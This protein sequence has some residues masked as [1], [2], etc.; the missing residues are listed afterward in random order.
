MRYWKANRDN[1]AALTDPA[2][3]AE[4]FD[5]GRIMA[6]EQFDRSL[7]HTSA[8]VVVEVLFAHPKPGG[9]WFFA[10]YHRGDSRTEIGEV[11]RPLRPISIDNEVTNELSTVEQIEARIQVSPLFR[12]LRSVASKDDLM[13]GPLTKAYNK[14][15]VTNAGI[16]EGFPLDGFSITH[17]ELPD[18]AFIMQSTDGR[19][20]P[21]TES[22]A[23]NVA[24]GAPS[25]GEVPGRLAEAS[26]PTR[27]E[28][29]KDE[30]FRAKPDDVLINI[31]ALGAMS[32]LV[33][34]S[35]EEESALDRVTDLAEEALAALNDGQRPLAYAFVD[36]A[37]GLLSRLPNE[38]RPR[39][40]AT[41]ALVAGLSEILRNTSLYFVTGESLMEGDK[42]I[43]FVVDDGKLVPGHV[44][45]M[46]ETP[47]KPDEE[48]PEIVFDVV[49]R[50]Q[51]LKRFGTDISRE[52]PGDDYFE[53]RQR[54]SRFAQILA[55][56]KGRGVEL[57]DKMTMSDIKN[58]MIAQNFPNGA[59]VVYGGSPVFVLDNGTEPDSP[60]PAAA[61]LYYG[62][63]DEIGIV[64]HDRM[65]RSP[66]E[67]AAQ[68]IE[69]DLAEGREKLRRV[70]ASIGDMSDENNRER[71]AGAI[72]GLM[73]KELGGP[74]KPA[75]GQTAALGAAAPAT[76]FLGD[77]EREQ[78]LD[79]AQPGTVVQT[80][81]GPWLIIDNGQIEAGAFLVYE[82]TG[83]RLVTR[84]ERSNF[85]TAGVIGSLPV[86]PALVA[87]AQAIQARIR[88]ILAEPGKTLSHDVDELSWEGLMGAGSKG[89]ELPGA[90]I[91][92]LQG[93]FA[94]GAAVLI[95][96]IGL[97]FGAAASRAAF[98]RRVAAA[99]ALY[100]TS[101]AWAAEAPLSP[102]LGGYFPALALT[103][104]FG[105]GPAWVIAQ[106]LA[107]VV[108]IALHYAGRS[109][110]GWQPW[111]VGGLGAVI[112]SP[113]GLW[114]GPVYGMIAASAIIAVLHLAVSNVERILPPSWTRLYFA[115]VL[116]GDGPPSALS[117]Q[118][119][120]DYVDELKDALSDSVDAAGAARAR[121][122]LAL[123]ADLISRMVG[124]SYARE[125][126]V[127]LPNL[128]DLGAAERAE[129]D[130][131]IRRARAITGREQL[132]VL[133]AGTGPGTHIAY[134][135]KLPGVRATGLEV[136]RSFQPILERLREAG[137]IPGYFI[138]D[139]TDMA[140]VASGSQDVV[141]SQ[142]SL[143]H[144][145][146]AGPGIGADRAAAE[147][148]R[149]LKDGGVYYVLT[150]AGEGLVPTEKGNRIFQLFS[151][152]S[153]R[154]L[155]ERNGFDVIETGTRNDN[156]PGFDRQ[157]VWMYARKPASAERRIAAAFP[158][159]AV[160]G[161]GR[162]T[163]ES[164]PLLGLGDAQAGRLLDEIRGR[165][166][167]RSGANDWA[168]VQTTVTS[169]LAGDRRSLSAVDGGRLALAMQG[170]SAARR[171][172]DRRLVE[173]VLRDAPDKQL[174]LFIN[175]QSPE[176]V[177]F[178]SALA[179]RSGGRIR[180]VEGDGALIEDRNGGRVLDLKALEA[181]LTAHEGEWEGANFLIP[182]DLSFDA[183][184]IGSDTILRRLVFL[185]L[186][187]S[188][189]ALQGDAAD[190]RHIDQFARV[191][192]AQA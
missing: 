74:A 14:R 144:L 125:L 138:A 152:G 39:L 80:R 4:V 65:L 81:K 172:T 145:L 140:P 170:G 56:M 3:L 1:E 44:I 97:L 121:A 176:D 113:L 51:L 63:I 62:G 154:E 163:L 179:A 42:Q 106:I 55:G 186:D 45:L 141:R 137:T 177:A 142:A 85:E 28:G 166:P 167:R 64:T 83:R 130:E 16:V 69:V 122:Q 178:F 110:P 116:R 190:L 54:I 135:N 68:P 52:K 98:A 79:G 48:F 19:L 12:F 17:G 120:S 13:G 143:L 95:T 67:A 175:G 181:V 108:F 100:R 131:T 58:A 22:E 72:E 139:M 192:A 132:D 160:E 76:T 89:P 24:V 77:V 53:Q 188:L 118:R 43:G 133:D 34:G 182:A 91:P 115:L 18:G 173:D 20:D 103:G 128:T 7:K 161:V 37:Q 158:E 184:G 29:E 114:L 49:D 57:R 162:F 36:E 174:V 99:S 187:Q 151:E 169:R 150:R 183:S 21:L 59:T 180:L 126:A 60:F 127:H 82:L 9:G 164:L 47:P 87:D 41:R 168:R 27:A 147:T 90:T 107:A 101:V 109:R 88:E 73:W 149:V 129:I 123:I 25:L 94:F 11:G 93:A 46:R 86:D 31:A 38:S 134:M 112:A 96:A 8:G 189:K 92:A 102:G 75:A 165:S 33:K 30:R 159:P 40:D 66:P 136:S 124:R 23:G 155:A 117:V 157:W 185:F 26:Q 5:F 15:S 61:I 156:R 35:A 6:M 153:L 50:G 148:F 78:L 191:I 84:V 71:L 70:I 32:T 171:A 111:A 146:D 2:R 105:A 10:N 104:R 119:L